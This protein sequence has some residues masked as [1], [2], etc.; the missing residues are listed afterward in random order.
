MGY[1]N[2]ILQWDM[3]NVFELIQNSV[4]SG[5]VSNSQETLLLTASKALGFLFSTVNCKAVAKILLFHMEL[6]NHVSFISM[7]LK[8]DD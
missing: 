1:T 4:L 5:T 3:P 2:S 7:I 8:S 6:F